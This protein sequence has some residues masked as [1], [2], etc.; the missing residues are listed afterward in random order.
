MLSSDLLISFSCHSRVDFSVVDSSPSGCQRL[1]EGFWIS[2]LANCYSVL[3]CPPVGL[4]QT[5]ICKIALQ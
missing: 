1:P 3:L 2:A 5:D 4:E